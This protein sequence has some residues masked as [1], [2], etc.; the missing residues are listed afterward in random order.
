MPYTQSGYTVRT[1]GLLRAHSKINS[2]KI[3]CV[4]RLGYPVVVGRIPKSRE[5]NLDGVIYRRI[6]P[7]IFFP[8]SRLRAQEEI[9]ELTRIAKSEQ[10]GVI[11][12]TTDYRNAYV[13]SQVAKRLS[14]PWVYEV[15]G[16]RENTWLSQFE[17]EKRNE[18]AASGYYTYAHEKEMEAVRKAGR[19][20]FLSEV[21]KADAVSKGIDPGLA[22]VI[23]NSLP[24]RSTTAEGHDSAQKLVSSLVDKSKKYIG[25]VS[26]LVH[27]EGLSIVIRALPFLPADVNALFVGDGIERSRLEALAR[28]LGVADRVV[29]AGKQPTESIGEWYGALDVFVVPRISSLVTARVTPIKT[30]EAM[31]IGIPVLAS[32]L[33]ALH[34]VTGE[35]AVYFA[36]ENLEDFVRKIKVILD[37][38]V[39]INQERVN[40]WL[41]TRT[42]EH[43]V[44]KL[45]AM[46]T[47]LTGEK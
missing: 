17:A 6:I 20:I 28:S 46:Y 8:N 15:R 22:W 42:W 12:T 25:T 26:S 19:T 14:I 35:L 21:A 43:N 37:G 27:Y 40:Q 1:Q 13:A 30:L 11:H 24:R 23:P 9:R 3:I 34:E 16:E 31:R 2:R 39:E 47:E 29:F 4:T 18:A 38:N 44:K 41:R 10:V 7:R 32:D 36:P 45:E 33:P 5:D